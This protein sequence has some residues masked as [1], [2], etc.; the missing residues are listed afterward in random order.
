MTY[1]TRIYFEDECPRLGCG[2]RTVMVRR[3]RKWAYLADAT[4]RR[5]RIKLALL[6]LLTA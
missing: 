2:W 3:G 1:R 6:E 4:G 5:Q